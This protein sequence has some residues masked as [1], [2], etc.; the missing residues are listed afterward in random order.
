MEVE[1]EGEN[2]EQWYLL[3][4]SQKKKMIKKTFSIKEEKKREGSSIMVHGNQQEVLKDCGSVSNF[5]ILNLPQNVEK[6]IM[7]H[8]HGMCVL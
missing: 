1:T 3:S 4:Y 5:T 7:G 6:E 8:M 2:T